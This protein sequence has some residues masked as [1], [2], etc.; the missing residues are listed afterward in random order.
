MRLTDLP[1]EHQAQYKAR[2]DAKGFIQLRCSDCHERDVQVENVE[3]LE[4]PD[5]SDVSGGKVPPSTAHML[6]KPVAFEKHCVACH[7]MKEVP[8][9]LNRE[10]TEKEIVKRIPA[11]SVESVR[12][13]EKDKKDGAKLSELV[14]ERMKRVEFL[15]QS[16]PD[17]CQKCHALAPPASLD[18]VLPSAVPT[19]WLDDAAFTHGK[20]LMVSC[21]ECHAA[22]Y[23]DD[24]LAVNSPKEANQIMIGGLDLCRKCHIQD[25][26]QR[27]RAFATEP[28]VAS[29][30]CID[31]HRYHIDR[32]A[33]ATGLH[34]TPAPTPEPPAGESN[35][36]AA[37]SD[38]RVDVD[39]RIEWLQS[40]SSTR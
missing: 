27:T 6:Y 22:A 14:L 26:E 18:V 16:F 39:A 5:D 13:G 23:Q 11:L 12:E 35:A 38:A 33:H 34:N 25:A 37:N 15:V 7:D 2:G 1:S 9:G 3:H 21:K 31:C 28:H 32:P 30:D 4:L 36:E 24:H 17:K 8:H 20:H 10:Q 19:R 40:V 29:A